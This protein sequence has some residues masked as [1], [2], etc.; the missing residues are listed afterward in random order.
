MNC[1]SVRM[2]SNKTPGYLGVMVGSGNDD[3]FRQ[4]DT[5]ASDF[6]AGP[7]GDLLLNQRN[8][9]L[10]PDPWLSFDRKESSF[11]NL[12]L[13]RK[14][15]LDFPVRQQLSSGKG[16]LKYF[17]DEAVQTDDY[18]WSW[19]D[20]ELRTVALGHNY[21]SINRLGI[22]PSF[23]PKS[24]MD[25]VGEHINELFAFGGNYGGDQKSIKKGDTFD[26][27][28]IGLAWPLNSS[29]INSVRVVFVCDYFFVFQ[30]GWRHLLNGIAIHGIFQDSNNE[31]WMF[32]EGYG[33]GTNVDDYYNKSIRSYGRRFV[34]WK[35]TSLN[36]YLARLMWKDFAKNTRTLM[37]KTEV[38][39][40][41]LA[42]G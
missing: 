37:E 11:A 33:T 1:F 29:L 38:A 12:V 39:D 20:S 31:L 15:V 36:Y 24:A 16:I 4:F 17:R 23:T 35:D 25:L 18:Y 32:Q 8:C 5:T 3:D 26:L 22:F 9:F 2:N 19:D 40:G 6:Q 28:K 34:H 10:D 7:T 41:R 30:T 13:T 21:L 42:Q 14:G 27:T